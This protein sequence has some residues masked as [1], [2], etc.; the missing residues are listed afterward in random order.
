MIKR[1]ATAVGGAVA[2]GVVFVMCLPLG[3]QSS[4][5]RTLATVC[6][7]AGTLGAVAGEATRQRYEKLTRQQSLSQAQVE[8][9]FAALE[10][11]YKHS[12]G[13]IAELVAVQEV[14]RL[15]QEAL[16]HAKRS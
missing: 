16:S 2:G 6:I 1:L 4:Y 15:A 10:D 9:L 7:S 12:S 11:E 3:L 5:F 13:K 14:R 8:A